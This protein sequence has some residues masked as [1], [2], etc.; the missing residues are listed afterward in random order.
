M[1]A[2][3]VSKEVL[4]GYSTYLHFLPRPTAQPSVL[5]PSE[6]ELFRTIH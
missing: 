2:L 3:V 5:I 6:T 4:F 1:L